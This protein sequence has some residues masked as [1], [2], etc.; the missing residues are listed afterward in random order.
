MWRNAV[1]T[2]TE[3]AV[4][5]AGPRPLL[6]ASR[7]GA[8]DTGR[9]QEAEGACWRAGRYLVSVFPELDRT[10]VFLIFT[11]LCMDPVMTIKGEISVLE[12]FFFQT[13]LA[14][15]IKA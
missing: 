2:G 11:E 6:G 14:V 12:L 7:R 8:Q 3:R 5:S 9:S 1:G 15:F 10:K 13:F 4:L